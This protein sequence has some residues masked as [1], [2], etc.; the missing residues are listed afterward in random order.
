MSYLETLIETRNSVESSEGM[1]TNHKLILIE[2]IEKEQSFEQ[3]NDDAFRY[4]YSDVIGSDD[5]FDF[6]SILDDLYTHAKIQAKVCIKIFNRFSDLQPNEDLQNWLSSAIRTVDCIAI[7]Y[8]QDILN[9]EAVKKGDA[10]WERSRYI[11]I[12]RNEVSAEKAGRI[13]DQLYLERNKMEHRTKNDPSIPGK[14]IL[15]T[16][17]FK[18][19]NKKIRKKFPQALDCFNKAYKEFYE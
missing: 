19:I 12:N 5:V 10:G 17:K 1:P 14:R 13:M 9:E 11:Q 16:P 7:H 3:A 15:I 6:E 18:N 8:L 4:F 2:L